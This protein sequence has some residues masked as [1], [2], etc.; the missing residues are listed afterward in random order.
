MSNELTTLPYQGLDILIDDGEPWLTQG[1][2]AKLLGLNTQAVSRAI[3]RA[4][5]R[6]EFD[7]NSVMAQMEH[8]ATD[9][10]TYTVNYYSMD[11]LLVVGYR[12][13]TTPQVSA[14]RKWVAAIVKREFVAEIT[15]LQAEVES[16]SETVIEAQKAE[17]KAEYWAWRNDELALQ[18]LADLRHFRP[19]DNVED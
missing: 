16:L 14:F 12:A 8:T 3:K 10:K 9:G 15:R 5:E 6:N 11:V 18:K 19:I 1:Q 2:M 13:D 4:V 7:L 17:A